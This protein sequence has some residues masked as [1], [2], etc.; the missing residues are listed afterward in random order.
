MPVIYTDRL[1]DILCL[2]FI[3]FS[4][5]FAFAQPVDKSVNDVV[6]PSPNMAAMNRYIDIPVNTFTG[7]PGIS[8]PIHTVTQGPLSVKLKLSY[9]ADVKVADIGSWVGLSWNLSIGAI[10]RSVVSYRDDADLGYLYESCDTLYD[11][12]RFGDLTQQKYDCEPDMFYFSFDGYSGKFQYSP[13]ANNGAGEW[14]IYPRQDII[15]EDIHNGTQKEII[16]F[17]IITPD[18]NKYLFG[19][20]EIEETSVSTFSGTDPDAEEVISAWYLTR[21]STFDDNHFI[22]FHYTQEHYK[23]ANLGSNSS[24]IQVAD[25]GGNTCNNNSTQDLKTIYSTVS[26]KRLTSITTSSGNNTVNFLA[27]QARDDID[28]D[29]HYGSALSAKNLEKIQILTGSYC[30]TFEFD[31][32]Y[33]NPLATESYEKR[34]I[35]ES[36]TEGGCNNPGKQIYS[37]HQ[38]NNVAEEQIPPYTFSYNDVEGLPNRLS[39]QKDHWG[40]FSG[41]SSNESKISMIPSTAFVEYQGVKIYYEGNSLNAD[42]E[43]SETHMKKGVLTKIKYPTGGETEIDYESNR[44][45]GVRRGEDYETLVL[46]KFSNC[47]PSIN[48]TDNQKS[49]SAAELEEALFEVRIDLSGDALCDSLPD[50]VGVKITAVD[51]TQARPGKVQVGPPIFEFSVQ[52]PL[53]TNISTGYLSLK[54]DFNIDPSASD[55]EPDLE[56]RYDITM[57]ILTFDGDGK[58]EFEIKYLPEENNVVGGLRVSSICTKESPTAEP[59]TTTYNYN[60]TDGKSTG[61]LQIEPRYGYLVTSVDDLLTILLRH[62]NST[63]L[64]PTTDINGYLVGYSTVDKITNEG[65][66]ETYSYHNLKRVSGGYPVVPL[67]PNYAIGTLEQH[68][69]STSTELIQNIL[70]EGEVPIYTVPVSERSK[71][72]KIVAFTNCSTTGPAPVDAYAVSSY[73]TPIPSYYRQ[74]EIDRTLDGVNTIEQL[75]YDPQKRY[76]APIR[77]FMTNSDGSVFKTEYKYIHDYTDDSQIK[78]TLESQNRIA[79][80]WQT[81]KYVND[82]QVDGSRTL[83]NFYDTNGITMTSNKN[84]YPHEIDRYEVSWDEFG[85][86]QDDGWNPLQ[87]ILKY[88][89]AVGLPSLV[90]IDGWN[91]N[92]E[93]TWTPSGKQAQWKFI[94]YIKDYDYHPNTDLLSKF[95]DI[96]GTS[97]SFEY[98]NL[99]RPI[100][101]KDEQRNVVTDIEYHYINGLQDHNFKKITTI[102]PTLGNSTNI[103]V[104]TKTFYDGLGRQI[105]N[106]RLNQAPDPSQ[107]I[108]INTEYDVQSRISKVY[109]PFA[110]SGGSDDYNSG[111]TSEFTL[112]TYEASPLNR[113][114]SVT[115]PSW[116]ATTFDYGNNTNT[117]AGFSAGTLNKLTTTDPNGNKVENYTDKRGREIIM[118][119]LDSLG[120]SPN[121]TETIWD[122]KDRKSKILPPGAT[123]DSTGLIYHFV[124]YPSGLLKIRDLP[125]ADPIKYVYDI[126]DHLIYEQDGEMANDSRWMCHKYDDYGR[127]ISMGFFNTTNDLTIQNGTMITPLQSLLLQLNNYGTAP[128]SIDKLIRSF[129]FTLSPSQLLTKNYA[130]DA[131][132]R[133]VFEGYTFPSNTTGTNPHNLLIT[134]DSQD[135]ITLE[136]TNISIP[137]YANHQHSTFKKYDYDHVGRQIGESVAYTAAGPFQPLSSTS[138]TDKDQVHNHV[139]NPDFHLAE[140]KYSY[141]PNG[142][143]TDI[144][145][146]NTDPL[147]DLQLKY[148]NPLSGGTARK[149]GDISSQLWQVMGQNS[150]HYNYDYDY[151]DRLTAATYFSSG[152]DDAYN[153]TYDYNERGVVTGI[154]RNGSPTANLKGSSLV[155]DDIQK[156]IRSGSNQVQS[157]IEKGDPNKGFKNKNGIAKSMMT[158]TYDD[159]GFIATDATKGVTYTRNFMNHPDTIEESATEKI[160]YTYDAEGVLH[161]KVIT[162]GGVVS[163]RDYIG[164]AEFLDSTLDII[165]FTD[166]YLKVGGSITYT[167]GLVTKSGTQSGGEHTRALEIHTTQ[168]VTNTAHVIDRAKQEIEINNTFEVGDGGVYHAIIDSTADIA[169]PY[170]VFYVVKDHL[171]N[172]RV[173][174]SDANDNGS[175]DTSEINQISNYYPFGA[176]HDNSMTGSYAYRFNGKE[177]E[178]GLDLEIMRY[179]ARN[180]DLNLIHFDGVDP[181]A[182]HP[183]QVDKSPYAYAWNNPVNLTDPDGRCPNCPDEAYV[184]L[185]EHVYGAQVGDVTSNGWEAIR[186]DQNDSGLQGALYKGTADSGFE[187]EHIYA[188]AGTQGLKDVGADVKQ[189]FG[190]SKQY[191]ESVGIAEG[192]SENYEGIS[193]TGHSL[194]GGLASANAFATE[195]KAVTFNAAG[196]SRATKNE[197]GLSGKTA[198]ITSYIV[199]GEILNGFQRNVGL[200]AEGNHTIFLPGV[201]KNAADRHRM[202]NVKAAFSI[203]QDIMSKPHNTF[204]Y[205]R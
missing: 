146:M 174:F 161:R 39:K 126:K 77:T 92:L 163:T 132:G 205:K 81:E 137:D 38:K 94:D 122:D 201:G 194:G 40:Y 13:N 104:A 162:S 125:D 21:I 26:G 115:L 123:Q 158:L 169:P 145:D 33:T 198:N 88:D 22:D 87:R 138:Y 16:G 182:D 97:S 58:V 180:F 8:I 3:L 144:K 191:S 117:V 37:S 114:N 29:T 195:G 131:V 72:Y 110:V 124:Y 193:F 154:T 197:L 82:V 75:H 196:I 79:V 171:G 35:L 192:L 165:H 50:R 70:Y 189:V 32:Y 36:V 127:E 1:S 31:Y 42:R 64:V 89:I 111:S 185:A 143:L 6:L 108:V 133:R 157:V 155:M 17:Q 73:D 152:T 86:I 116:Y 23:Y 27:T 43:P 71:G 150:A 153:S 202:S 159:N 148:D 46:N 44:E 14:L 167:D 120:A 160:E 57:D 74:T 11:Q 107:H 96:D 20:G 91:D 69:L 176:E 25:A 49:L 34:L 90:N 5:A 140:L 170:Q 147:F 187:G 136:Q 80:P 204:N 95:T 85:V 100:Q 9:H 51:L 135:N 183:N 173:V 168:N 106:L 101:I 10:N 181:I 67:D 48:H 4:G 134:Y 102:Y 129:V 113:V 186:V 41:K 2:F 78:D 199:S 139:L 149:N 175:I 128:I 54:D 130:F 76:T 164:N 188:T 18:G 103:Q 109:E 93:Y 47:D 184:P 151:L 60:D 7:V 56:Y 203:Y 30:K 142:F 61:L 12:Q 52:L 105:Q 84:V 119:K 166:G 55:I 62:Y 99:M 121:D 156:I 28:P 118:R 200:R 68:T 24:T 177:K 179:G 15:I 63:S 45:Y 190:N 53:A 65:G 98:D 172:T 178:L 66:K 112:T 19:N 59:I 83:F 141:L